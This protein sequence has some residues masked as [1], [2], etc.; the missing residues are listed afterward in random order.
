MSPVLPST[1]SSSEQPGYFE[2][3]QDHLFTV[4]HPVASPLARVLLIGPFAPERNQAYLHWVRWARYLQARNIEVLRFDYRGVGE[5]TGQF[6]DQS[7]STWMEDASEL[8]LWLDRRTPRVPLFLNG[9]TL[10][11]IIAGRCFGKG[12]GDGLLLW[13]PPAQANVVLHSALKKWVTVQ[14]LSVRAHERKALS[15][16]LEQLENEGTLEVNSYRW[17]HRL[18]HESFDFRLPT[19]LLTPAGSIGAFGRPVKIVELGR[20]AAPLVRGGLSG[21]EESNDLTWLYSSQFDWIAS[22]L[23]LPWEEPSIETGTYDPSARHA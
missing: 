23:R 1:A 9:L 11:A 5:S 21:H 4:L 12:V 22:A 14:K 3:G 8:A 20:N 10:G 19:E 17:S 13:S 18:W 6:H 15:A 7:F 2:V 16:Y